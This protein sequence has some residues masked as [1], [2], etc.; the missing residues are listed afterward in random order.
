MKITDKQVKISL[1][2]YFAIFI[3]TSIAYAINSSLKWA[4]YPLAGLTVSMIGVW[5]LRDK[6]AKLW[7]AISHF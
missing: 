7:L 4:L 1:A 2:I 6:I 5:L 3:G